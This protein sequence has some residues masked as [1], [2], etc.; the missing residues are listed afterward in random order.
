MLRPTWLSYS[1]S[2]ERPECSW[3]LVGKALFVLAGVSRAAVV[4]P[5]C[6]PAI[7]CGCRAGFATSFHILYRRDQEKH[8]VS[9][10]FHTAHAQAAHDPSYCCR[11]CVA[12]ESHP[13]IPFPFTQN[14]S[15]IGKSM[16]TMV[17]WLAGNADL[18]PLYEDSSNPG[19]LL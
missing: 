11:S 1:C 15:S 17:T 16:M 3:A 8:D 14:F 10:Q 5:N 13:S 7:C 4:S 2:C 6:P 12:T 19:M 18:N 9:R